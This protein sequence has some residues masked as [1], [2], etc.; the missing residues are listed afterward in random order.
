MGLRELEIK[1]SGGCGD[2]KNTTRLAGS[3]CGNV[4]IIAVFGAAGIMVT[5]TVCAAWLSRAVHPLDAPRSARKLHNM[6]LHFSVCTRRPRS[7]CEQA[8]LGPPLNNFEV[9][10]G[11]GV[12]SKRGLTSRPGS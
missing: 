10:N 12:S 7:K 9:K 5:T 11:S 4:K 6:D 3:A 8:S 2:S 1:R